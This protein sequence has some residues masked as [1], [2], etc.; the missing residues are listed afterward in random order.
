MT[1]DS[2]RTG[3]E[4]LQREETEGLIRRM[5]RQ[6]IEE[7]SRAQRNYREQH[8]AA[9]AIEKTWFDDATGKMHYAIY[10]LNP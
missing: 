4:I 1:S 8:G 10:P 6:W 3:Y 2:P 5:T 9:P 7:V